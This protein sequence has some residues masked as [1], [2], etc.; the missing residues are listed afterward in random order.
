MKP[1]AYV[2]K[3]DFSSYFLLP[4]FTAK[5]L[6]TEDRKNFINFICLRIAPTTDH[7]KIKP[8]KLVKSFGWFSIE[9]NG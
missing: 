7:Q 6:P 2:K 5:N 8:N 1:S 9:G 4:M 3:K